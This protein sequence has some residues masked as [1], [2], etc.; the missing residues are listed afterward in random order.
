MPDLLILRCSWQGDHV[1]VEPDLPA[2][3]VRLW[4][5]DAV[6]FD[7]LIS[8][9]LDQAP[10]G[11]P[12]QKQALADLLGRLEWAVDADVAGSQ[13]RRSLR[14]GTRSRGTWACSRRFL[15]S[16][17]LPPLLNDLI[18]KVNA[19]IANRHTGTGNQRLDLRLSLIAETAL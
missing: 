3:N 1:C 2:V 17:F 18:A 11:H 12:A 6:L 7:W 9:D 16:R 8:T 19:L 5:A 13:P 4:R 15:L 14:R 10:I